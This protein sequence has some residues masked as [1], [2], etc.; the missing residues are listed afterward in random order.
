[1]S[2]PPFRH[3]AAVHE[4]RELEG[5]RAL[6]A[7][8]VLLTHAAFMSGAIGRS[9]L[10]GFLARMDIGVAVFFVLSG[11]LLY[12]SNAGA[13]AGIGRPSPTRTFFARRAARLLPA[14]L[15]CLA[16]VLVLV[17]ESRHAPAASW[18]ANLLQVQAF[19]SSWDL[20]GL[21]QLWSLSTEVFFYLSLPLLAWLL[22]LAA[23][24]WGARGEVWG[25]VGMYVFAW[26]VRV[27]A[28]AGLLSG[29][30][31]WLRTLPGNL[32]WFVLGMALAVLFVNRDRYGASLAVIR[33]S[34]WTLYALA[35]TILWLLTTSIAGPYDLTAPSAWQAS[36]KHLGYGL[37]AILVVA[38]AV[39]G[40]TSSVSAMLRSR[41]M[42]Y[43]G[44]ISYGFFLWHL[45]VMFWV[46]AHLGYALFTGH[47]WATTLGTL[48]VGLPI[49][50]AS[51]HLVESKVQA[52]AR[53][54]TTTGRAAPATTEPSV[55]PP[56]T[57]LGAEG[58]HGH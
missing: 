3:T 25:L 33:E 2:L 47:F 54:R 10:P 32:D 31:S 49:S 35:A 9:I 52:L 40:A 39:A 23:R 51:W 6:A 29:R 20:P 58:H 27:A 30:I 22:R 57:P 18:V 44:T 41:P 55:A 28:A 34:P 45:P 37:F 7:G 13:L 53:R 8:A 5:L 36:I 14:W 15:L 26:A 11:F 56:P 48:L 1:M 46:R 12:R 42:V 16:G 38:P 4:L 24:R 50:A 43:L 19:K 17:P 21:A